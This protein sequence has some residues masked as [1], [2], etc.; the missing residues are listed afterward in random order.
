M[1]WQQE[2]FAS[3]G[4]VLRLNSDGKL[5]YQR[6]YDGPGQSL[7][8]STTALLAGQ[9]GH[10]VLTDDGDNSEPSIYINGALDAWSTSTPTGGTTPAVNFDMLGI[11]GIEKPVIPTIGTVLSMTWHILTKL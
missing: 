8:I 7:Y 9:W 11:G 1:F 4:R 3:Y 2:G 5:F 10:I 6:D